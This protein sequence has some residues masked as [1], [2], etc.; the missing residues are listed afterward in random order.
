MATLTYTK[1]SDLDNL[2]AYLY[3]FVT[4]PLA[5]ISYQDRLLEAKEVAVEAYALRVIQETYLTA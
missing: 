1:Y 5:Y 4:N 2:E 3:N